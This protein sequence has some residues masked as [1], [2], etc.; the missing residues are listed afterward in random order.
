MK[1]IGIFSRKSSIGCGLRNGS[2]LSMFAVL[3]GAAR[4]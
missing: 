4:V 1:A 2:I 3:A